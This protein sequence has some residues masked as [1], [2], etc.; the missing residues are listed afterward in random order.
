MNGLPAN[1]HTDGVAARLAIAERLGAAYGR[2]GKPAAVV[3][4]GS[5]SRGQ[6]DR[7]SDLE[8]AVFWSELPA[9]ADRVLAPTDEG[10]FVHRSWP[11]SEADRAAFDDLFTAAPT[12]AE[13]TSGLLVEVSHQTL[14]T[15]E[16]TLDD[17]L[18]RFDTTE[19]RRRLVAGIDRGRAV[20]G[21]DLLAAWQA[22]THHYPEGLSGAI[23]TAYGQIDHF[24][25]WA[26]YLERGPNLAALYGAWSRMVEHLTEVIYAANRVHCPGFK[27]AGASLGLL[28]RVPTDLEARLV[29]PFQFPPERGAQVLA[30]L[31]EDTLD[32]AEEL[33]RDVDFARLRRIFRY[34]RT[35]WEPAEGHSATTV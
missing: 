15:T 4:M 10:M 18:V 14:E 29:Q 7:Y 16:R 28:P 31:V 13:P 26:M 33:V 25:R 34:R 19:D 23:V 6:A 9:D 2:W 22:R 1:P 27:F 5:T 11:Y 8:L 21:P 3:A 24:W 32:L 30:G 17:V 12:G 20:L 35:P